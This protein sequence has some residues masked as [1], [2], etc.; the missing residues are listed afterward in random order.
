MSENTLRGSVHCDLTTGP[1]PVFVPGT[2]SG[3]FSSI[4][5]TAG[6]GADV[7]IQIQSGYEFSPRATIDLQVQGVQPAICLVRSR[8][9]DGSSFRVICSDGGLLVNADFTVTVQEVDIG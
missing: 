3:M 9:A 8:A 5:W 2:N 1:D 6:P 7:T 4:A